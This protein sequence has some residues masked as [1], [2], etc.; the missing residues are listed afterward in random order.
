MRAPILIIAAL[1]A[2]C[3]STDTPEQVLERQAKDSVSRDMKDPASV[4]FRNVEIYA[5][6]GVVCGEVN[7]KNSYGGMAGFQGFVF[8]DS[9]VVLEEAGELE[10]IRA[11]LNCLKASN[12]RVTSRLEAPDGQTDAN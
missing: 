6:A 2:G 10:Y 7:S 5:R 8:H 1:V 9:G 11:R 12:D 4:Q 3:G